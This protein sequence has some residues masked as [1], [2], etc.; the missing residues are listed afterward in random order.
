MANE[1]IKDV[2]S[3]DFTSSY[4]FCMCCYDKFPKSFFRKGNITKASQLLD[5]FSYILVVEFKN[6]SCK[7]FN[8]FISQNKCRRIKNGKYDNGRIISADELEIVLTEIDFKFILK[9]YSGSYTIKES[10]FALNGYLPKKLIEFVLDKYIKKTEYKNVKGK[11]L[12]YNLEKARFNSIYGMSVTNNIRDDVIFDNINGWS[13]SPLTNEMILE[14]LED[15]KKQGFLSFSY[16]VYVTSIAR[17]NLLENII[18]LDD[19]TIY[20]DTDSLKLKNGFDIKIIEEYNKSVMKRIKKA[21]EELDIPIEKFM[22]KDVKGIER[23][24]GIFTLDGEYSK[25]ITQG[26]KKYAVIDKD[27]Y[28]IHITVSGVPKER[29]KRFKKIRRF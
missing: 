25:F 1:I 24:L 14:K 27:D 20:S 8:N 12:E 22:P 5:N 29:S 4:P 17:N 13:E 2:V 15:E 23:P 18:K 11:E 28:K 21:S 10:Y 3:Y 9:A 26:A 6:I 7:Y 19:Y 16:G